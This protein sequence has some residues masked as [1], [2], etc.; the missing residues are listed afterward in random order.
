[1]RVGLQ[2]GG[3]VAGEEGTSAAG[4]REGSCNAL[5]VPIRCWG[6]SESG[7]SISVI[8]DQ[9]ARIYLIA[10]GGMTALIIGDAAI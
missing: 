4:K 2:G 6:Q 1:M 5:S 10:E 8:R 3:R 7:A 9:T